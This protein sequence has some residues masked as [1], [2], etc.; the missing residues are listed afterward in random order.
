MAKQQPRQQRRKQHGGTEQQR[1]FAKMGAVRHAL[2]PEENVARKRCTHR[3]GAG[4]LPC[5]PLAK[6]GQGKRQK[7]QGGANH[8]RADKACGGQFLQ[9]GFGNEPA[10]GGE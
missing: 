9:R 4:K 7:Q 1:A 5:R 3:R 10:A 2:N 8:A 6:L